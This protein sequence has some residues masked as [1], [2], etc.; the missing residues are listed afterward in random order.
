VG[1]DLLPRAATAWRRPTRWA[2]TLLKALAIVAALLI[3]AWWAIAL[4]LRLPGPTWLRATIAVVYALATVALFVGVRPLRRAFGF[5]AAGIVV[6]LLWYGTIR[7][8][9]DR[10][11][12]T[13]VERLPIAELNGDILTVHNVR[14]FDYRSETDYTPHWEDRTYNLAQLDGADFV[15]SHWGA[16]M[17]AHTIMSWAFADGQHLAISIETRRERGEQYS[18]LRGFFREYE[19]YYVVAD[20]RDVIRVRTNFRGED[21]YVYRLQVPVAA[22]RA[23][24]LDYVA[25]INRLAEQPV[26]YNAL[27]DNCTTGIRVHAK[28]ISAAA[29]W[30]Y[31]ILANGSIDAML[32]ERGRLGTSRSFADVQNAAHINER[33]HAAGDADDF[34]RRIREER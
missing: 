22:A 16:P 29:P 27:V 26:F 14:N 21:V 25:T 13:D 3:S 8:S 12:A 33:A 9:N 1:A 31:R 34:S 18:A 28:N 20:E 30:D 4:D 32:Y 17:I 5:W 2:L 23:M 15:L 24:L 6:L 7:P 19:L 11:W 10:A